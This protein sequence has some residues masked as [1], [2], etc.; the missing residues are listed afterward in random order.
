[1]FELVRYN[2][3]YSLARSAERCQL[4]IFKIRPLRRRPNFLETVNLGVT[5]PLTGACMKRDINIVIVVFLN[6]STL[7][8]RNNSRIFIFLTT[9]LRKN[10]DA[11]R[12]HACVNARSLFFLATC[13]VASTIV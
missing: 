10:G 8:Y 3:Y 4:R 13:G 11:K 9:A 5:S 6:D 7:F 1:M 12:E 2:G